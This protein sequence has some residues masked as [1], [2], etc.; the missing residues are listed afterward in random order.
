MWILAAMGLIV[1][2]VYAI[3]LGHYQGI[4]QGNWCYLQAAL[5][6]SNT[7]VAPVAEPLTFKYDQ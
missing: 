4:K 2:K 6:K 7:I 1:K 5:S 3:P